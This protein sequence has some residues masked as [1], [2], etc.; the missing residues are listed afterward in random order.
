MI[1]FFSADITCDDCLIFGGK[2]VLR[3][4]EDL[5]MMQYN[6]IQKNPDV[7][8]MLILN[9]SILTQI[10]QGSSFLERV[11]ITILNRCFQLPQY[12]VT[13]ITNVHGFN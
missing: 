2:Q 3:G 5:K 8:E 4:P 13:F 10:S 9:N 11:I 12:T 6:I 7:K 1:F